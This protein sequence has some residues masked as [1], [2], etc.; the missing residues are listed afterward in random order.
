MNN[1]YYPILYLIFTE[2]M[3]ALTYLKLKDRGQL[4]GFFIGNEYQQL[5]INTSLNCSF[6]GKSGKCFDINC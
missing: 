2:Y 5:C 3:L 6:W 1:P 4:N